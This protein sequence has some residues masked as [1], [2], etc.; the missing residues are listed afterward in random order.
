LHLN[1]K[2]WNSYLQYAFVHKY[3]FVCL[4]IFS[5]VVSGFYNRLTMLHDLH[6]LD[7]AG[8]D[9]VVESTGHPLHNFSSITSQKQ[10]FK[11]SVLLIV[12]LSHSWIPFWWSW[13]KFW[14]NVPATLAWKPMFVM[15]KLTLYMDLKRW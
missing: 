14:H 11:H 5:P 4:L 2:F 9:N 15:S 13:R 10:C 12:L 3:V 7:K 6:V 8:K 1:Y